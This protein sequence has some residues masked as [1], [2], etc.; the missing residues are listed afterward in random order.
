[1]AKAQNQDPTIELLTILSYALLAILF[2][3]PV[4]GFFLKDHIGKRV[5]LAVPVIFASVYGLA[6]VCFYQNYFLGPNYH[7]LGL[8]LLNIVV[9]FVATA[10]FSKESDRPRPITQ[11]LNRYLK[12]DIKWPNKS[13]IGHA[14]IGKSLIDGS[15]YYLSDESRAAHTLVCGATGSGKTTL[16]KS[17]VIDA[18]KNNRPAIVI[19][20][21]GD[22][23]TM[24]E[25][26]K[27]CIENGLLKENFELFS[28]MNPSASK[29]YNPLNH[30]S[31]L[32]IRD[33]I[34]SLIEWSDPYYRA[35]ALRALKLAI[36]LLIEGK[37]IVSLPNLSRCLSGVDF[38]RKIV[39]ENS[40]NKPLQLVREKLEKI[41][42]DKIS[43]LASKLNFFF[44]FDFC[45]F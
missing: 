35:E 22:M 43:L 30:G 27:L 12:S 4:V 14:F 31:A 36:R 20:P 9:F 10:D 17:L 42:Q 8:L 1:M 16:L 6:S 13:K 29:L 32:E 11:G 23:K 21:K 45:K 26:R 44:N 24:E 33:R 19:D 37:E 7:L 40:E 3:L 18:V 41:P 2:I 38:R 25:I 34:D 28:L 39:S 15:N 5:R